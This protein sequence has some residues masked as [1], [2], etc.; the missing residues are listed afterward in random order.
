MK[1]DYKKIIKR[2][3][4]IHQQL[5]EQLDIFH[6]D[7]EDIYIP[8][9][10]FGIGEENIGGYTL[11][12]L[13]D[14]ID[15]SLDKNSLSFSLPEPYEDY[16]FKGSIPVEWLDTFNAE[17]FATPIIEKYVEETTYLETIKKE[18][19]KEYFYF[20]NSIKIPFKDNYLETLETGTIIQIQ[21]KNPAALFEGIYGVPPIPVEDIKKVDTSI[22][23]KVY[24]LSSGDVNDIRYYQ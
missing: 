24:R 11:G 19:K 4:D 1:L 12:Y 23:K 9:S 17:E 6:D 5:E 2:I 16:Y 14:H 20:P 15:I 7:H 21:G 8:F 10:I 3:K 18:V 22:H 13:T